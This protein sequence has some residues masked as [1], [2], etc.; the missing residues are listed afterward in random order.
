MLNLLKLVRWSICLLLGM[1]VSCG[2]VSVSAQSA[3][4]GGDN[5]QDSVWVNNSILEEAPYVNAEKVENRGIIDAATPD[6]VPFYFF[7]T[8]YFTNSGTVNIRKDFEFSTFKTENQGVDFEPKKAKVFHNHSTGKIISITDEFSTGSVKINAERIINKGLIS[9]E[10]AGV[11]DLEGDNVNLVRGGIEIKSGPDFDHPNGLNDFGQP[12]AWG[13]N[14]NY[15]NGSLGP[16]QERRFS[17]NPGGAGTLLV[18][19]DW[20]VRDVF[21]GLRVGANYN[22]SFPAGVFG[23]GDY[24]SFIAPDGL[25]WQEMASPYS[26]TGKY[27][28]P[29]GQY[30]LWDGLIGGSGYKS[31][32]MTEFSVVGDNE[33]HET[34]Q[35]IL[36]KNSGSDKVIFDARFIPMY[37]PPGNSPERFYMG[38]VASFTVPEGITNVVQ[39]V[40][41]TGSLYVID[42]QPNVAYAANGLLVNSRETASKDFGMP[43]NFVVTRYTPAEYQYGVPGSY[44]PEFRDFSRGEQRGIP[45][46]ESYYGFRITNVVSRLPF[47]ELPN[48]DLENNESKTQAGLVRVKGKNLDLRNARIRAEGGIRIETQH[49]IGSTNA[50]LD[51]QNLSLNIGSTNGVLVITNLVKESV[52]RF[53]G[54][55]EN[56]SISWANNYR[57]TGADL[58]ERGKLFFVEDPTAEVTV[59]LHYHFFVIDAFLNTEIPVTVTDLTVN[60]DKVFI[61]DSMRVTEL[62]SVNANSISIH[63]NLKLGKE[64][65]M[66]SGVNSK[67]EGQ[68]VWDNKVA[69]TLKY[70]TNFALVQIPGQAQFGNDRI[71]S[72]NSWVNKGKTIAQDIFIDSDYVENNGDLVAEGVVNVNSKQLVLQ[73]GNINTGES[74]VLNAENLKMRFHT[75]TIGS[76]LILNVSNVL[77]DGGV[78]ANNNIKVERGI[79]LRKKPKAGDL[80]GTEIIATADD[81]VNQEMDWNAKDY[82]VSIKGFENNAALGRLILRNG[83]LSKFEFLGSEEG[84]NAIYIDYI[85]FDQLTKDD[86]RDGTLPVLD[87]KP[88]FTLYFAAS[89]LPAEDLDGMYEGRLRWVKEYPGNNSSMPVYISGVD[90]TIRVN[91][92]FRQSIAFDTDDDGI[93]NGY[94]LSPFGNG[95]PKISSVSLNEESKIN[96]IWTGLPSTLYRLEYKETLGDSSWKVITEY[97]N[98]EYIVKQMVHQEVLS[99]KKDS[100]FYRVL[101]VE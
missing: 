14:V 96:L 73:D 50:V 23:F 58:I 86:L 65:F 37:A 79:V 46:N 43:Q 52:E 57:T 91:R 75:N 94:D 28:P 8:K 82:G 42:E 33:Y 70:F 16:Y 100:K 5:F 38:S 3:K 40:N 71:D 35:G 89:N 60:S 74:L 92:S 56:Y 11:L 51:S 19:Q 85:E 78:G 97:Y 63:R 95:V 29:Y 27:T 84:S 88:G 49:L 26:L 98:N 15:L 21:W 25:V 59:N 77:S 17:S 69:P 55:V 80:L 101:Y 30:A 32:F 45:F 81:F 64:T 87:I 72:Y 66:G 67:T 10:N 7:N 47:S 20:G 90:K 44:V 4:T 34:Y 48:P 6:N 2:V 62:L 13:Y 22:G 9:A 54:G 61:K 31:S 76:Q 68:A 12:L 41:E 1:A 93:A 53:T 24:Y 83:K 99:N 36:L 39:G 18:K